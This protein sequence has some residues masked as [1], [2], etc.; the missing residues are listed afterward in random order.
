MDR[1][2]L[3]L[4]L[5]ARVPCILVSL[6]IGAILRPTGALCDIFQ[7]E[8][9]LLASV[10]FARLAELEG[11]VG[12]AL[13]RWWPSALFLLALFAQNPFRFFDGSL[14]RSLDLLPQPFRFL[15]GIGAFRIDGL[16]RPLWL[17][18]RTALVTCL[19]SISAASSGV[20]T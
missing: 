13:A 9:L 1:F 15:F 17:L 14:D 4:A 5:L 11:A 8:L 3:D 2:T 19:I 16:F 12:V 6:L 18:V 10:L 7:S 20:G